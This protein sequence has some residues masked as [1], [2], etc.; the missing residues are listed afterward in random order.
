MRS[1]AAIAFH[2]PGPAGPSNFIARIAKALRL[3]D[4]VARRNSRRAGADAA[5][6]M[7]RAAPRIEPV[8]WR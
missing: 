8:E 6:G 3:A 7:P 2:R 1:I 4:G 5:L